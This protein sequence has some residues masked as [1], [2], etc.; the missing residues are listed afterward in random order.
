MFAHHSF[1][2]KWWTQKRRLMPLLWVTLRK[3]TAREIENGGKRYTERN[4]I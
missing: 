4:Q 2:E 3:T 1:N